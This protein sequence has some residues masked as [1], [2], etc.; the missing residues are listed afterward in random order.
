MLIIRILHTAFMILWVT[1]SFVVGTILICGIALFKK[2]R[3]ESFHWAARI[4][5]R[6]ILLFS[7]IKTDV[8]GQA[9]IPQYRAVI[10]VANH[11]GIA[12][13][14]LL[15]A[16]L[17]ISFRFIIKK[18]LFRIPFFGWYLKKCRYIP[19]NRL[20]GRAAHQTLEDMVQV[21]KDGASI[22]IFPEGTRSRDGTLGAF[23]RGVAD[24]Y[25]KT[26][27]PVLPIAISGSFGVL[28]KGSI[29]F[30]PHPV[31]LRIGSPVRLDYN[32]V[33]KENLLAAV[34]K[35][36]TAVAQLLA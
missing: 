3:A 29:V 18:E 21:I 23:K 28:K 24:L 27:A 25:F 34:E 12:D 13:I 6:M 33:S 22:L 4:W 26:G 17:P 36:Q 1:I 8:K 5:A 31:R 16:Y 9:N 30:Y 35:I 2:N 20:W 11:Q 10:L 15:L 32:E 19:I 7:G 14:L